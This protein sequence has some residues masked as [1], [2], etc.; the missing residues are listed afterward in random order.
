M[1]ILKRDYFKKASKYYQSQDYNKALKYAL[2][3]VKDETLN[4]DKIFLLGN[5]YYVLQ[6]YEKAQDYY[7]QILLLDSQNI[8]AQTNYVDTLILQGKY[9]LAEQYLSNVINEEMKLFLHG[10]LNF[11]QEKYISAERYFSAYT[12]LRNM[13]S[14]GWN[15]LSQSAQKNNNYQ[16]ALDAGLTAVETSDGDD[17]HQLNLAYTIYEIALEKGKKAV[18]PTLKKWYQKHSQNIIVQQVWNIFF[19]SSETY[20]SDSQYVKKIFDEFAD[21][22]DEVLHDLEYTVPTKIL[23]ILQADKPDFIDKKIAVLDLGCGTGLCVQS[24]KKILKNAVFY[25]VDI[26]PKMLEK[27]ATKNIYKKLINEDVEAYLF[28]HKNRYEMIIAADVF[29]YFGDLKKVFEGV[30]KSLKKDGVIVFSISELS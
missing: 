30:Y 21:S 23:Q 7:E 14:W 29:T 13:D 11:E 12:K 10:K 27:A 17:A 22:F 2:K 25:G 19:S 18:M 20:R 28:K 5:I 3:A 6:Y 1:S 16:L 9:D 24:L 4:I 15:M 8:A 26:S